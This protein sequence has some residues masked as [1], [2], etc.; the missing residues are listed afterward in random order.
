[1]QLPLRSRSIM[2]SP[3][4]GDFISDHYL[5]LLDVYLVYFTGC[6][7]YEGKHSCEVRI[8]NDSVAN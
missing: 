6:E 7:R 5:R 1:M 4:V 2:V 3:E 8:G